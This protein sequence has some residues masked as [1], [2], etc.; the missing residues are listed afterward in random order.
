LFEL[1]DW[2]GLLDILDEAGPD[3]VVRRIRAIETADP[4]GRRW[5]RNKRSDDAT[6]V[7]A[8]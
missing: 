2:A 4:E 8:R 7:Y 3:E 1:T 6:I 5:P